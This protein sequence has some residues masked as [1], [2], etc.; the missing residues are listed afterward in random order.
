M[1]HKELIAQTDIAKKQYQQLYNTYESEKII[2]KKKQKKKTL[3]KYNRSNLIFDCKY[4]FYPYYNIKSF[5]SIFLKSKFYSH[6]I[7]N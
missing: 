6:F 3:S 2:R 4:S 7:L 5:N 1:L